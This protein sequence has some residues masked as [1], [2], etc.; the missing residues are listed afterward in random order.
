MGWKCPWYD[1]LLG[2]WLDFIWWNI[3]T[4]T[5]SN[6]RKNVSPKDETCLGK[7]RTCDFHCLCLLHCFG[8]RTCIILVLLNAYE[9]PAKEWFPFL[10]LQV[11][12]C[13]F[14]NFKH[15]GVSKL[16]EGEIELNTIGVSSNRSWLVVSVGP[17]CKNKTEMQHHIAITFPKKAVLG[18]PTCRGMYMVCQGHP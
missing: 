6:V 16:C 4:T 11:Q 5:L 13:C 14:W 2:I 17:H 10:G 15:R 1:V 7:Y 9:H 3:V 8:I 18:L 12:S